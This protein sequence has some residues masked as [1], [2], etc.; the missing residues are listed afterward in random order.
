MKVEFSVEEYFEQLKFMKKQYGQEEDLYPWVYML[1]QMVECKKKELL[2]EQYKSVSIRD[3]H[4]ARSVKGERKDDEQ[5]IR[6]YIS[7]HSVPDFIVFSGEN[8]ENEIPILGCVEAK[9]LESACID[10]KGEKEC[11]LQVLKPREQYELQFKVKE[12]EKDKIVILKVDSKTCVQLKKGEEEIEKIEITSI[13]YK[14]NEVVFECKNKKIKIKN[15][16]LSE[17]VREKIEQKNFSD[18]SIEGGISLKYKEINIEIKGK[19]EEYG[20]PGNKP[21][22]DKIRVNR[23]KKYDAQNIFHISDIK[24]LKSHIEN[25]KKVL[26][27]NGFQFCM[28][29]LNEDEE[30]FKIKEL[31]NLKELYDIYEKEKF[32][33][34]PIE[35]K[36]DEWNK[37]IS[38]LLK[39][40]WHEKPIKKLSK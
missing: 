12:N 6:G 34:N 39:I 16:V 3:V 23:I 10:L 17:A 36:H 5:K 30:K 7:D 13:D 2:G 15:D 4:N 32:T 37:L 21:K 9:K 25:Y 1:L 31:G 28:I 22:I 8:I 33:Q 35:E 26:Y 20:K 40:D 11:D 27:T 19:F 24:E 29:T 18:G 38:E 14:N